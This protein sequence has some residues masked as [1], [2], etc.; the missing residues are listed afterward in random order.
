L[1]VLLTKIHHNAQKINKK[2]NVK[3][4]SAKLILALSTFLS[5]QRSTQT[6]TITQNNKLLIHI[7]N[8]F[9]TSE[10]EKADS[11]EIKCSQDVY[12]FSKSRKTFVE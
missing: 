9:T 11:A 12:Q 8:N 5:T 6:H 3:Y 2:D 7:K 4:L 10:T 1:F